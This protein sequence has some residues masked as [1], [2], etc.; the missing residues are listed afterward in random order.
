MDQWQHQS[1]LWP[2]TKCSFHFR[3]SG[4]FFP[5]CDGHKGPL[6]GRGDTQSARHLG[7]GLGA[8]SAEGLLE[9]PSHIHADCS[10]DGGARL[11]ENCGTVPDQDQTTEEMLPQ[12]QQVGVKRTVLLP[13]HLSLCYPLSSSLFLSLNVTAVIFLKQ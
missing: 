4:R 6:V 13:L 8:A 9:K 3:L 11:P 12:E 7:E 1:K 5:S 2:L 10:E